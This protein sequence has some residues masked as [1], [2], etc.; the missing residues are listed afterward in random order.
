VEKTAQRGKGVT[1][2]LPRLVFFGTPDFAVPSLSALLDCG[3][4]VQ[5]VVTQPDRPSGRG[6][7]LNTPPVKQLAIER[8]IPVFQ[9]TRVKD[10]S[11]IEHIRSLK[12]ECA[13]VVAYGQLLPVTLLN[14]FPLG[15]INV[16][17]SLLPHHRGAAPIQRSLLS[18][19]RETGV[20]LMLLD[21]GMDT[22]AV[23][24]MQKTVVE[25]GFSFGALHN[26]LASLGAELLCRTL[27]AWSTGQIRP[28]PQDSTL[29]TYAPPIRKE[30][31][32]LK[33]ELPA[34]VLADTVR[35]FDPVPGA[36]FYLHG[37]RVKCF[38]AVLLPLE[39]KGRAGEV[40]GGGEKGLIIRASDG[41]CVALG[42]LQ[43]EG[44]RRL[45]ASDFLRGHPVESGT[46][47]E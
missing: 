2:H 14:S 33:W 40:F 44:Q 42:S 19:D 29:A 26:R 31:L 8:S 20:S 22:G 45:R 30:E 47:L 7:K 32:R 3:A 27:Q 4:P 18:G 17:A 1:A 46:L 25:E 9:P 23:L 37:R 11:A 36:Y 21:E 28:Q 35:A 13:V 6:K 12:A 24:A 43:L 5:L 16:H 41:R 38:D 15:A 39:G 34:R 10:P